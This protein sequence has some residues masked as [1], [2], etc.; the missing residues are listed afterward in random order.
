[1]RYLLVLA[2]VMVAACSSP[3]EIKP[4]KLLDI[5][6]KVE[7]DRVWRKDSGKFDSKRFGQLKPAFA[8]GRVVLMDAKGYVS[9]FDS[10]SGDKLWRVRI[11]ED[12][13]YENERRWY[14]IPTWFRSNKSPVAISGGVG[15]YDDVVA[16]GSFDGDVI[17]LDAESGEERWRKPVS[18][19]VLS[20]PQ[21]NG[22]VV[23]V[24][25]VDGKIHGL[26]LATGDK[27]WQYDNP[28][29]V[30]TLRGSATPLVTETLV[31][32]GFDSGK[33]A[34]IDPDNGIALWDHR[35]AIPKGRTEFERIVDIDGTPLLVGDLV[36][37]ASYQGR[38]VALS[39]ASGRSIWAQDVSTH[40]NIS[41]NGAAIFVTADD[42]SIVAFNLA[43]G[44]EL[45][46]NDQLL[47]RSLTGPVV[48][49]GYVAA[50]DGDGH[51][52]VFDADTGEYLA[53]KKISGSGVNSPLSVMGDKLLVLD[54]KGKLHV[55]TLSELLESE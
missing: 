17:L 35:V 27:R 49:S 16:V 28:Q 8:S 54:N 43:N 3:G 50:A 29:A 9:A 18:S 13:V 25:T 1:M 30:L 20:A 21:P 7:F 24:H 32:A 47:R 44:E 19:E 12:A 23:V 40:S 22:D 34:A 15:L 55:L 33:I 5:E 41:S 14:R 48:V 26:D 42:D 31:V 10:E 45:W 36:F 11:K 51:L 53:R 6:N 38:I 46:T 4:E 2:A 37:A 39:R 52:H